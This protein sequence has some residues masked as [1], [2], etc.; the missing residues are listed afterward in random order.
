MPKRDKHD[1]TAGDNMID[2]F[3]DKADEAV[4]DA[5]RGETD[6]NPVKETIRDQPQSEENGGTSPKEKRDG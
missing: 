4:D 5:R 6:D 1:Q 3:K 2:E